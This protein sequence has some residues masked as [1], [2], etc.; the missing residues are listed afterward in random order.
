M[1]GEVTW[2]GQAHPYSWSITIVSLR[3]KKSEGGATEVSKNQTPEPCSSCHM[4]ARVRRVPVPFLPGTKS[5]W[6]LMEVRWTFSQHSANSDTPIP[7][8]R[9]DADSES[10][11]NLRPILPP[12]G[13]IWYSLHLGI[14]FHNNNQARQSF[15]QQVFLPNCFMMACLIVTDDVHI[16]H[17][18][19]QSIFPLI[20]FML[21]L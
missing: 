7:R 14:F 20:G 2:H 10:T 11:S 3:S 8:E 6:G 18:C 1:A 5:T 17:Q 9:S 21:V 13:H 19:Q 15:S 4:S 12:L 16:H